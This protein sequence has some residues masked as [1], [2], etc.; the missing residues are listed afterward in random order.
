MQ[1]DDGGGRGRILPAGARWG[2]CGNHGGLCCGGLGLVALNDMEV[3]GAEPRTL[4]GDQGRLRGQ[5]FVST[6][7]PCALALARTR[8]L[9]WIP[10]GEGAGAGDS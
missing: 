4:R 8:G 3:L 1:R 6:S 2:G 7:V 9:C 10:L 5:G